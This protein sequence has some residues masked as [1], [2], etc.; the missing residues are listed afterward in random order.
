MKR[1]WRKRTWHGINFIIEFFE[2]FKLRD[3]LPLRSYIISNITK[4]EK[5]LTVRSCTGRP[6]N[7]R[8]R[9]CSAQN[10]MDDNCDV[11]R[12]V[13]GH[14]QPIT[15]EAC[16]VTNSNGKGKCKRSKW[17]YKGANCLLCVY[18]VNAIAC[19]FVANGLLSI[20]SANSILSFGS[21]NSVLS[22]FSANC[23]HC[24]GCHGSY[25]CIGI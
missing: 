24:I 22:I 10:F 4:T 2:V 21:V 17:S 18:A 13:N 25:M 8:D 23:V 5:G 1:T 20:L 19:L 3:Q 11:G 9:L 6:P 12:G 7:Q 14:S 15:T 16:G